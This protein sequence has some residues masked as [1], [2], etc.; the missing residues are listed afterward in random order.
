MAD[1]SKDKSKDKG[2][3]GKKGKGQESEWPVISVSAHP[4]ASNSIRLMKSWAGLLGFV[5][6]GVLSY[7]AGVAPFEALVRAL[8]VGVLLYVVVWVLAVTL[9]RNLVVEEARQEGERRREA[10]EEQVRLA[11]EAAEQQND[12]TNGDEEAA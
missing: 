1:K 3:K 7:R 8:V 6:V 10:M 2:K 9:W 11:R 12:G 5:L 4:R